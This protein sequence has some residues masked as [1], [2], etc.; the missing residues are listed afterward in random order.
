MSRVAVQVVVAESGRE[1]LLGTHRVDAGTS[2][3]V[4]EG[5]VAVVAEQQRRIALQPAEEQ[6]EV[7]VAIQVGERS[8]G[9]P[10]VETRR[11]GVGQAGGGRH[12]GEAEPAVVAVQQIGA[13]VAADDEQVDVAVAVV[14]A[15]R[16]AAS[17]HQV[18]EREPIDAEGPALEIDPRAVR[19]I[20]VEGGR[21]AGPRTATCGGGFSMCGVEGAQR[22]HD[23]D[24]DTARRPPGAAH[25]SAAAS[26]TAR[27]WPVPTS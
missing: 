2:G 17:R 12:L 27:C 10:V 18:D 13:D 22:E 3:D 24:G 7:A 20:T 26:H 11:A 6:V 23:G 21:C 8:S 1:G 9:M 4:V 15:G 25:S 16:S 14:V 19:D 5:A